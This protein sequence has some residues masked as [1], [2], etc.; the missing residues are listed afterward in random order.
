MNA[1]SAL[2]QSRIR[3]LRSI[4]LS[5]ALAL[6]VGSPARS[7][8][9][10]ADVPRPV[11]AALGRMLGFQATGRQGAPLPEDIDTLVDFVSAPQAPDRRYR[12]ADGFDAP[13]AYYAF[14][15][16][17]PM[18]RILGL[19]FNPDIPSALSSPASVRWSRWLPARAGETGL[20]QLARAVPPVDR[21][22]VVRATEQIENTPD[23]TSGAYHRYTTDRL[24]ILAS[25]KGKNIL[26]S[27]SRQREPSEVGKKGLIVGTDTDWNYLYS[28]DKGLSRTGLGWVRSRIYSSYAVSVYIEEQGRMRCAVFQWMRAGWSG[29]NMVRSEHLYEGLKRYA[30]A[31]RAVMEDPRLPATD[32][33]EA[34]CTRIQSLSGETLKSWFA[35]FLAR[36]EAQLD[37]SGSASKA[38]IARH[39]KPSLFAEDPAGERLRV[40]LAL[41]WM[42]QVLGKAPGST[43]G[44]LA[45]ALEASDDG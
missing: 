13:S 6:L 43:L 19:A 30:G 27:I 36:V 9:P 10:F 21:P 28:N 16:N 31:F 23:T 3:P 45:R 44:P 5:F 14:D 22:M 11:S 20:R 1:F 25:Q 8:E 24:L 41:E 37:D 29:I 33:I 18:H 26:V 17:A 7:A 12:A 38:W 2:F 15:V 35:S 32:R 4:A 39:L 40:R 42:K 34:V